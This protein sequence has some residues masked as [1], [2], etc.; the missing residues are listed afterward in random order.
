[1]KTTTY[2]ITT[3]TSTN[4]K[5]ATTA[6]TT[7]ATVQPLWELASDDYEILRSLQAPVP[8]TANNKKTSN[9]TALCQ[10]RPCPSQESASSVSPS[11]AGDPDS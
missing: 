5:T 6:T 2:P 4:T 3:N 8:P 11:E 10:L 1:M 7:A 9:Q